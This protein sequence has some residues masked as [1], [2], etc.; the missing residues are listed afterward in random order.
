MVFLNTVFSEGMDQ[1]L[2]FA[3]GY[4]LPTGLHFCVKPKDKLSVKDVADMMR[5]H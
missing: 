5:D 3:M 2:D 1:Y 4:I